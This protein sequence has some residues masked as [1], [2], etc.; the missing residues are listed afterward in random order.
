MGIE[1]FGSVDRGA[2]QLAKHDSYSSDLDNFG[3]RLREVRGDAYLGI[4]QMLSTSVSTQLP[5]KIAPTILKVAAGSARGL[6]GILT[7]ATSG[8]RI[9]QTY[10]KERSE[11]SSSYQQTRKETFVTC[12]S[13]TAGIAAGTIG[14]VV[15]SGALLAGAPLIA[16]A[17]LGV[18]G[19]G[20]VGFATLKGRE[21]AEKLFDNYGK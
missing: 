9:G 19:L 10:L 11:G 4:G 15:I 2:N 3:S 5:Q 16:A 20:G 18:L 17:G 21:L 7:L 8:L 12:V 6:G 13:A 14:G 1:V